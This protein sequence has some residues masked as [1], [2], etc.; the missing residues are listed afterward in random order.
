MELQTLSLPRI[1]VRGNDLE[2]VERSSN[3]RATGVART[4][5]PPCTRHGHGC[6][7]DRYP[8][9]GIVA[10]GAIRSELEAAGRVIGHN[11]LLIAA[12]AVALGPIWVTANTSAFER[13]PGLIIEH[14]LA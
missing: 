8:A 7:H 10:N 3:E 13:F 6:A 2:R 9:Y 12:H 5:E 1:A 11:D 4:S 14:W